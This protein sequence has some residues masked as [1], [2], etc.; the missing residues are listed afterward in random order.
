MYATLL[1]F[2]VH[3][4]CSFYTHVGAVEA[5][6]RIYPPTSTTTTTA[7]TASST[8]TRT[9]YDSDNVLD[10]TGLKLILQK[11]SVLLW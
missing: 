3:V 10:L 11:H 8:S 2:H 4:P 5:T 7:T 1:M 9:A 6:P